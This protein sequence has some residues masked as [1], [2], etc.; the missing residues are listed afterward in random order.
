MTYFPLPRTS[1]CSYGAIHIQAYALQ[2]V[3]Q[4]ILIPLYH[5]KLY[6]SYY[7]ITHNGILARLSERHDEGYQYPEYE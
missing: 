7:Y 1:L 3:L 6:D 5:N 2:L 4:T